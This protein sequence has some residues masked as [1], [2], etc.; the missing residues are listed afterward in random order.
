MEPPFLWVLVE[1]EMKW[2]HDKP[3][4]RRRF[5]QF[6][7][8]GPNVNQHHPEWWY[9]FSSINN[10][11]N[12]HQPMQVLLLSLS[13]AK[14]RSVTNTLHLR[15]TEDLN[16][17]ENKEESYMISFVNNRSE[18][19]ILKE[20]ETCRKFYFPANGRVTQTLPLSRPVSRPDFTGGCWLQVSD[21]ITMNWFHL[22]CQ[23]RVHLKISEHES[24]SSL[25]L[26]LF[27]SHPCSETLL[28]LVLV[29][30]GWC[31]GK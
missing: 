23:D 4:R 16:E 6:L 3:F 9:P 8:S 1:E 15:P 22:W 10:A 27:S 12:V 5:L 29:R 7:N 2:Q 24:S 25:S 26:S 28:V 14:N 17:F 31:V 19:L 18:L 30:R 13:G 21:W 11:I 20:L